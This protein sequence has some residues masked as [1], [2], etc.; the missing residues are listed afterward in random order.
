MIIHSLSFVFQVDIDFEKEPI[1]IG[2]DG[3]EVY[4]KEI[5]PSN[6]EVA[7]VA[8]LHSIIKC[9]IGR[10]RIFRRFLVPKCLQYAFHHISC[11]QITPWSI[12]DNFIFI[13]LS[14][15]IAFSSKE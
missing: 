11:L 8:K 9:I 5:W 15:L 4:F 12:F 13:L 1:G 2:K 7:E 10:L 6:E 3:K 14:L